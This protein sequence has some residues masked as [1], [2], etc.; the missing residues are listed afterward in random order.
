MI[1]KLIVSSVSFKGQEKKGPSPVRSSY[2]ALLEKNE[3]I[4]TRANN[5]AQGIDVMQNS[6]KQIP[7]Q[8]N[9]GQKLD[10]IA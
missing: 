2:N 10:I 8:G 1:P 7:M 6:G 9:T 5:Q 4:A 3:Q